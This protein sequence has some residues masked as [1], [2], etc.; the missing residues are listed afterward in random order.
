MDVFFA[1][2]VVL[3]NKY[4]CNFNTLMFLDNQNKHCY[5]PKQVNN[6]IMMVDWASYRGFSQITTL[7]I[8]RLTSL[9][10]ASFRWKGGVLTISIGLP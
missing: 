7:F 2:L 8:N 1:G 5:L 3:W 4:L 9:N 6:T 10:G